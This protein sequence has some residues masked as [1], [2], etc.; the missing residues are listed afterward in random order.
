MMADGV[1][2]S[3][4]DLERYLRAHH[5]RGAGIQRAGDP[6]PPREGYAAGFWPWAE[7]YPA[8]EQAGRLVSIGSGGM[9]GMRV[10]TPL[11]HGRPIHMDAQLL[12]PGERTIAHRNMKSET[13]LV[14]SAPPEAVFV[15]EDEG[16]PMER[17]DLI[18]S[19]TWTNHDHWNRGNEPAVFV[20]AYDTGYSTLGANLNERFPDDAPYQSIVKSDGYSQKTQ[21][22]LRASNG[23]APYPIS[24]ARYPLPP[25]RYPWSET[26][27]AL[28]ALRESEADGDPADGLHLA[29]TSPV[30]GGPTLPTISWAV[31][32]LRPHE[33][34]GRHRHNSTTFYHVFDGE[35]TV[36]IEGERL[37]W[38]TGDFF[39]VPPWT[40]HHHEH[41]G[42]GGDAVVFSVDD[43]PAMT[44][45]GFY[46]NELAKAP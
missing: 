2:T 37:E 40:W 35:G 6:P 7:L 31:Q 34:T 20:D 25:V 12:M 22:R 46:K 39:V 16:F 4:E 18:V 45:L 14:L 43:W 29:F 3:I 24:P 33:R 10:V 23:G 17:G 15:C 27:A 28:D 32:L 21:G 26:S 42:S 36:E 9:V 8:L 5:L 41:R 19:P 1:G 13:R 11:G 30:D 38:T 44:K